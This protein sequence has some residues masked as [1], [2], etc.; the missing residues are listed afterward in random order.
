M[1]DAGL[2]HYRSIFLSDIHLGTRACKAEFLL[3]F[4]RHVRC[5]HLYLVGDIV[6][7]WSLKRSWF[8][9]QAHVD[10]VQKVLKRARKGTRVTYVPGNHDE[11]LREFVGHRFGTVRIVRDA[12]H[13][14]A[15]GRRLLVVH[16]DEHDVV[17]QHAKWV[18]LVGDWGYSLAVR[19]NHALN[20]VRRWCGLP[21]WSLAGY[22]KTRVKEAVSHVDSFE[23]AL[24]AEARRRGLDGVVCGHVH[25]AGI[26]EVDG[27]LYCNDGDWVD[28]CTALVEHLDG[29]LE[30]VDWMREREVLIHANVTW[31]V[32]VEASVV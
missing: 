22:L 29:R 20:H 19:L 2:R 16:G 3:D 30:I 7:G 9:D 12:V 14:T 26:R 5:E 17:V 10:F 4:L 32:L 21:Y 31:E 28:S 6:D 23:R 11:G 18:A 13:E 15:D 8:W 27:M 25:T 1:R 24:A